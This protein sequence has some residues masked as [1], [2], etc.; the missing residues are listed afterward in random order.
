MESIG[1]FGAKMTSFGPFGAN[2]CGLGFLGQS[3]GCNTIIWELIIGSAESRGFGETIWAL[4]AILAG[5][6]FGFLEPFVCSLF[7][8]SWKQFGLWEQ[9]FVSRTKFESEQSEFQPSR[10]RFEVVGANSGLLVFWPFC[11]LAFLF[12]AHLNLF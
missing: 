4:G 3:M 7:W 1:P 8:A 6:N 9:V 10:S 5:A 11:I 12:E 2:L